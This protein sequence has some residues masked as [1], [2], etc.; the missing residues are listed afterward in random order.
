MALGR[1]I[2]I[3]LDGGEVSG[4]RHAELVNWTGQALLCPRSRVIELTQWET[5]VR[6]PGVYLLI[7]SENIAQRDAYIGE[8]EIAAERIKTHLS[9]KDFWQEAIIFTSKDENLTKA[10]IKYL[11]ARI[12]QLAKIAGRYRLINQKD[13]TPVVLPRADKDAMEEYLNN[14]RILLGALGH[15]ILDPIIGQPSSHNSQLMRLFYAIKGASASGTVTDDGFVV[16]KGSTALTQVHESI[17]PSGYA[18]LKEGLIKSGK[19]IKRGDALQFTSDTLFSS[20]SAAAA[21]VYGNSANG[22]ICWKTQEGQ[23]LKDIE[24]E[25][26]RR[27][28]ASSI[29]E[30]D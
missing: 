17:R 8:A 9:G 16:F 7:G 25:Q 26:A 21:V 24:E 19:L 13:E 4:I 6:R 10:H 15:R 2:R 11:E 14:A 3:Y 1:S 18:A 12:I 23:T 29:D 30:A 22:R 27:I 5:A 28:P 20:A